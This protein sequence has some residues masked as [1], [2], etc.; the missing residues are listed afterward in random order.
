MPD[1][2]TK[3]EAD[4]RILNQ[5]KVADNDVS[6]VTIRHT[7]SVHPIECQCESCKATRYSFNDNKEREY[8]DEHN[9]YIG[10]LNE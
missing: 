2:E 5:S 7:D 6:K 3:S 9:L 10:D 4:I 8:K 1:R